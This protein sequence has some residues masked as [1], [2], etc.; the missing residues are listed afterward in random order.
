[1][2][3]AIN[4][5]VVYVYD[6]DTVKVT[7]QDGNNYRIRLK[8]I[9]APES[10]QRYGDKSRNNLIRL[11]GGKEVLIDGGKKDHHGRIIAK[12]WVQPIDCN[13]CPKSLDANLEQ[14][15][16]GMAWWYSFFKRDQSPTD[17][18]RYAAAEIQAKTKKAGLWA[19]PNP[20]APYKWRKLNQHN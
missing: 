10:K 2:H 18:K 12:L 7:D 3:S 20:M 11:V 19:D 4:G 14:V 9:D 8:G 1:M 16:S 13:R 5:K 15:S 17:R 6:G